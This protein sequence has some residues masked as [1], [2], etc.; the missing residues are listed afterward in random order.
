MEPNAVSHALG[1]AIAPCGPVIDAAAAMR[2]FDELAAVAQ[3]EGWRDGLNQAW[4]ALAPVFAA[5]PYLAGLAR[6]DPERLRELLEADPAARIEALLD[7]TAAVGETTDIDAAKRG[8]R[9]LKAELHLLT[10]LCDLGGVWALDQVTAALSRFADAAVQAG[11][12]VAARAEQAKGRLL[13]PIDG[14]HGPA[15]GLFCLAL[16]KHGGFEL[17]YSSD[18]DISLFYAPA[19]L[20]TAPGVDKQA[21]AVRLTQSL[22]ALL[23]E[24]TAD[25]YVFR[26]DL[27]LRPDPSS[28]P[29][30]LPVE[31]ALTYYESA[32]QNWERAAMIKARPCG[33]DMAAAAAFLAELRPFIWRRSLDFASIA[34]IH[35]I[36]RQIHVHKVDERL[37]AP[38]H[39]LKLGAGGIRE[40]EFFV[41][42]Q[43]LILGGRDRSLRVSRTLDALAALVEAGQVT[44]D[45]AAELSADY[46]TLRALEHR[47]QMIADEQT[48]V[49]PEDPAA[50][51]AIAALC[52]F[53]DLSAFDDWVSRLLH[54]VNARYGQ[55]FADDEPL[56]SAFGSLVFTGVDDDPETLG[57]LT[58]MGFTQPAQVSAQIRAWHHGRIAAT[59]TERGRELFT[60]LAPRLLEACHQVGSPDVA[61]NRFGD[62]FARLASGV[63]IQSLFL[64]QPELFKLVVEVM[65]F[66][67]ALAAT[68]ARQPGA[69]DTMLDQDFFAPIGP[70]DMAQ[71]LG[72]AL[73]RA[74][75]FEAAMGAA[76]RA[77][78]EQAFRIGVQVM[79]GGMDAEEA[80]RAF[81]ALADAC[82]VELARAALAE[83]ARIGGAFAGDVAVVAL[84]KTGSREMTARSDLDLMTLYANVEP[85]TASADKGWGAETFFARFTQRLITALSAPTADGDLYTVDLQLRPSGRAGP[86]AVSLATFARYYAGEAET[87]EALALTRARVVWASSPAFAH[88][89]EA[90]IAAALRLPRDA[91]RTFADAADMRVLMAKERPPHGPWDLKLSPGGL[92]DIEFAAQS[93]QIVHA[94]AGGPLRANTGQALQALRHARLADAETL[95]TLSRAWRLQQD[96]T[97][98]LKLALDDPADPKAEPERFRALLATAGGETDFDTLAARLASRQAEA[99]AAFLAIVGR[100]AGL[101][102]AVGGE[103]SR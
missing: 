100:P 77:H 50:R 40:I 81:A 76:R 63:Q 49:L 44:P 56:S 23:Q 66:A 97:Q 91:A 101:H 67:P 99:H 21:M 24:R 11:L 52:G 70:L 7:R 15:P 85:T 26:V 8:L 37:S 62:F 59:R 83:T 22:A 103:A 48:H 20:A 61:F 32:G 58:R 86:V 75:G 34:D 13:P 54:R 45:A 94:A 93:L 14:A 41:Q 68:L 2:T 92:V 28:T 71:A 88:E 35:A 39:N 53:D 95:I 87:W 31:A 55:L 43:Q 9:R 73:S 6:R 12:A 78:R 19:A 65:A 79:S 17:N 5:A 36:K 64:A 29:P 42:T 46:K 18:I 90:A 89:A 30:V 47:T 4:P 80:G 98:V 69:I 27:R 74:K 51:A 33:G 38:G 10:A 84:G 60:R 82:I 1:G 16:G 25:G 96:L 3:A 72:L 102:G 57:T